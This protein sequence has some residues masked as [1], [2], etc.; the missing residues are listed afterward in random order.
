M[1]GIFFGGSQHA[2]VDGCAAASWD[3]GVLAG[4]DERTSSYSA[5]LDVFTGTD[6][7]PN[8]AGYTF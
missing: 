5:I 2:P 3:S 1:W 4:E 8:L 7:Y 6:V